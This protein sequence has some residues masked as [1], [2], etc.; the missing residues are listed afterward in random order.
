MQQRDIE[1]HP[2]PVGRAHFQQISVLACEVGMYISQDLA[3]SSRRAQLTSRNEIQSRREVFH[4]M[5]VRAPYW[6]IGNAASWLT[7]PS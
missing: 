7:A 1:Q 2:T 5:V 4:R 3:A 6:G